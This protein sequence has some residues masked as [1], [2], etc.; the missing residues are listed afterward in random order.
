[1]SDDEMGPDGQTTLVGRARELE[2][3]ATAMAMARR[4]AAR[5][6][7]L[8]GEAGIGKTALAE[9]AAA[10]AS[11]QG[12]TVV[13]GRAWRAEEAPP[14]WIWQ[15]VLGSLVRRT[16][17]ATRAHRATVAWLV[18]LVPELAGSADLPPVPELDPGDARTAL[19]RAVVHVVGTAAADRPLLVVLDDVHDA[20]LVSLALATLVCRSLPDSPLLVVTTQRPAASGATATTAASLGELD[21]QGVSVLVGPL[22]QVAV[23]A[24][25]AMLRV[26]GRLLRRWRGCIGQAAATRSSSSSWCAGRPPVK[27][28]R[29]GVSCRS[30]R[31]CVGWWVSGWPGLMRTLGGW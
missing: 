14:Y 15:Q 13:W 29:C 17:V 10:L 23:A 28:P 6:V 25:A 27:G 5:V 1:V 8:V 20:D 22:N 12:W 18:E 19:H 4:G 11:G 24:Q 7:H 16:D 30:V 21:R 26:P 9:H 31:R 2:A 3:I